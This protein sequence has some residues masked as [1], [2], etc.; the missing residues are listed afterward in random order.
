MVK[1]ATLLSPIS[2][3]TIQEAISKS[4]S[5]KQKDRRQLREDDYKAFLAKH[6]V[7]FERELIKL[8]NSQEEKMLPFDISAFSRDYWDKKF[9]EEYAIYATP[10]YAENGERVW[11]ELLASL[12]DQ[13]KSFKK[14][15]TVPDFEIGTSFDVDQTDVENFIEEASYEFADSVNGYTEEKIKAILKQSADEGWPVAET[16]EAIRKFFKGSRARAEMIA[17]TEMARAAVNGAIASYEQSG[18]V[19][20]KEWVTAG[21]ERVCPY[22]SVMDARYEGLSDDFFSQGQTLEGS[23]GNQLSFGYSDIKGPPLHPRCRCDILPII[24]EQYSTYFSSMR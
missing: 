16:T 2:F 24:K 9:R 22:C 12:K 8:F 3:E 19:V 11:K 4:F 15:E 1:L 17:Q 5:L 23:D 18:V 6:T 14:E 21:D 20:G 13:P 10:A 7:K